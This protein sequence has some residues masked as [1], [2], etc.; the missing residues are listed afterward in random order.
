MLLKAP[1]NLPSDWLRQF[2]YHGSRRFVAIYWEPCV[3]ESS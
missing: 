3:V 1:F 2:G